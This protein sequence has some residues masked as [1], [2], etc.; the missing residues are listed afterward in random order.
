MR[1]RVVIIGALP[2]PSTVAMEKPTDLVFGLDDRP[3]LVSWIGVGFQNVAVMAPY[4]VLV[5]LVVGA[6]KLPADR[7]VGFM[8][9][10][11]LG[12]AIYTLLQVNRRGPV[13]SGYLSP[14]VVSAIFLPGCLIAAAK[15]GMP[16]VAGMIV[17]AG[18]AECGLARIVGKLRK[19]FPAVVSGIILMAVGL[20]LAHIGMRIAWSPDLLGS[21]EFGGVEITFGVT[22]ATMVAL[23]VW[24]RGP[25]RVFCA[26]IGIVAGYVVAACFGQLTPGFFAGLHDTPVF[27]LPDAFPQ[28][29]TFDVSLILPFVIASVASGLRTVGTLTT[30]QQINDATWTRPDMKS[31]AGGVTA[32]GVGCAIG[33]LF[34]APGLSASPSLVGIQKA[35]GVTSRR[36]AWSIA[37]WLVVLACLPKIA[38][39][40]VHMPKPVMAG[41]LFFNGTFMFVGGIQVALSRPLGLRGTFLI[42]LPVLSAVGVMLFPEFFHRLPS[43]AQPI[44]ESAISTA[45]SIAFLLNLVFLIGRW[46]Y[47]GVQIELHDRKVDRSQVEHFIAT[48]GKAWK[49]PATDTARISAVVGDLLDQ[50]AADGQAEDAIALR[51]GWDQYDV[52]IWV[53]YRGAL[54][55]IGDARPRQDYVEEQAFI[56]GLSGYLSGIHA[57]HVESVVKDSQCELKLTFRI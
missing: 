28:G 52:T 40:I 56:S 38:S 11:M 9:M 49:L 31:I 6:A 48:E 44:T 27:A 26:L 34:S 46:S 50:I 23:S 3:P 7:A 35:T 18:V 1:Q 47:S 5:A 32:D 19:V 16:L 30:C 25:L 45:T 20:D 53:R 36:V 10:A 55:H 41:A 42:G 24:G 39:L 29:I 33:G 51:A 8:S 54:P 37:L 43:W 17:V 14:P 21:A 13:G 22:L 2:H 57:D 15:G 4:L 12:I